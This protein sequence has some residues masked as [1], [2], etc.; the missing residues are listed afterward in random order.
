MPGLSTR[1]SRDQIEEYRSELAAFFQHFDIP[2]LEFRERLIRL[3]RA[4]IYDFDVEN[5]GQSPD[6]LLS[7][8]L[9]LSSNAVFVDE[10]EMEDLNDWGLKVPEAPRPGLSLI[11]NIWDH[12]LSRDNDSGRYDFK[13]IDDADQRRVYRCESILH[14]HN[15][16]ITVGILPSSAGTAVDVLATLRTK[17]LLE[18]VVRKV[19]IT[20]SFPR[21]DKQ[22]ANQ[23]LLRH[24][25]FMPENQS[26]L[27]VRLVYHTGVSAD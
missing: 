13:L 5:D 11:D 12:H 21:F 26:D 8:E 15:A 19:T 10:D 20:P 7:L 9:K 24:T 4:Y 16:R 3:G 18:P 22:L 23:F 14:G 1:L 17:N 6:E 25:P 2:A 27:V